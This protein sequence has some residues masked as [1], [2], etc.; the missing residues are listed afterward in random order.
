MGIDITSVAANIASSSELNQLEG[1]DRKSSAVLAAAA[2][3]QVLQNRVQQAQ[4]ATGVQL[5]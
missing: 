1:V 2:A 3:A 5:P 4:Q